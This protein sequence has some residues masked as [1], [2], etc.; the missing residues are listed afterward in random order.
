M[1]PREIREEDATER[2]DNL[3]E[4]REMKKGEMDRTVEDKETISHLASQ[5]EFPGFS[6]A[7]EQIRHEVTSAGETTDRS[8]ERQDRE[9]T[10]QVFTPQKEH[11]EELT[12]R[13][14]GV[15]RDIEKI[16]KVRIV[17]DSAQAEIDSAKQAAERGKDKVD[18]LRE[19]QREDREQGERNRNDQK[20]RTEAAKIEFHMP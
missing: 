3:K 4:K 7:G 2:K 9:V 13:S 10:D 1:G 8:F 16:A 6:E 5:L 12:S 15:A 11:E 18:R 17:T 14:E 19:S 20:A